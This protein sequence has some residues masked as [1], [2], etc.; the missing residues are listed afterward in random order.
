MDF[1]FR[2]NVDVFGVEVT[3][4]IAEKSTDSSLDTTV[5]WDNAEEYTIIGAPMGLSSAEEYISGGVSEETDRVLFTHYP[6]E[7]PNGDVLK[8]DSDAQIIIKTKSDELA[9]AITYFDD[10]YDIVGEAGSYKRAGFRAF[11][12]VRTQK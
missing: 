1:D 9:Y 12:L 2:D 7:R 10:W 11:E 3:L 8:D 4:I 6:L 5:D